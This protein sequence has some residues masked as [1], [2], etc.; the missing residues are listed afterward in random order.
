VA[1]AAELTTRSLSM[2][3]LAAKDSAQVA[4][5]LVAAADATETSVSA[6]GEALTQAGPQA[7]A[8]ARR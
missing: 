5:T 8:G 1:A 4:N 7:A 2:F 3:G 6:L